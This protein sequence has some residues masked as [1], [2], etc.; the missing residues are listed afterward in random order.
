M[1]T[2]YAKN[3]IEDVRWFDAMIP[4]YFD[5][6]DFRLTNKGG[7]DYLMFLGRLI[8]R[9]GVHIAAEIADACG[10]ELVVA[11]AGGNANASGHDNELYIAFRARTATTSTGKN[12]RYVGLGGSWCNATRLLAG[13]RALIVPTT[14]IE[15]FGGVAVEAMLS[16]TPVITTDAGA[17]TET[18]L[19]GVTG[20]RFHTLAEGITAVRDSQMVNAQEIRDIATRRYS[21]EAVAPQFDR[22]FKRLATLRGRGWYE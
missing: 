3:K 5:L 7:G 15:P 21:L 17:F 12:L 1:H 14:Y 9:K 16:G 10:M 13:A 2:V 4:N 6:D 19:R 20:F 8:P 18:V 22:W 11:G